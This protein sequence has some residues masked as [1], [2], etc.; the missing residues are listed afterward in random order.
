MDPQLVFYLKHVDV[1]EQGGG[2]VGG[3]MLP[4]VLNAVEEEGQFSISRTEKVTLFSPFFLVP[5]PYVGFSYR[6]RTHL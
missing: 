1:V 4:P 2:E 6:Y 3:G 5:V